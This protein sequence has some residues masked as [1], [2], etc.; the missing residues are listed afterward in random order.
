[1]QN[2]FMASGKLLKDQK[3][4]VKYFDYLEKMG[5]DKSTSIPS[6][7]DLDFLRKAVYEGRLNLLEAL[8][9]LKRRFVHRVNRE[10]AVKAVQDIL[11][12]GVGEDLAVEMVARDLA[13]WTLEIAEILGLLKFD[14]S[15]LR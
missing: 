9:M 15:I 10:A 13:A 11:G 6:T 4:L 12:E 8:T 3:L 2:L 5:I 7:E 14:T 1:M